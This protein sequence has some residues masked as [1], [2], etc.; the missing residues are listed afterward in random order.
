MLS[1]ATSISKNRER[2]IFLFL[3]MKGQLV[4]VVLKNGLTYEA[5][6]HTVKIKEQQLLIV[7]RSSRQK[8][9]NSFLNYQ[10]LSARDI[11]HISAREIL[12]S[13][14]VQ[15]QQ[16]QQQASSQQSTCSKDFQ[17]DG[18]ITRS[19]MIQDKELVP[20]KPELLKNS[21]GNHGEGEVV[22]DGGNMFSFGNDLIGESLEML[23]AEGFPMSNENSLSSSVSWDQFEV[24]YRNFGVTSTYDEALYTTELDKT[25]DFYLKNVKEAERIAR[26][27]E[28]T[29]T[30][31]VQLK[32]DRGQNVDDYTEEELYSSVK[33]PST[34]TLINTMTT[35]NNNNNN[36]SNASVTGSGTIGGG[37][38]PRGAKRRNN[39]K[40]LNSGVKAV[41]SLNK[42]HDDD[43]GADV[44]TTSKKPLLNTTVIGTSITKQ[45]S[46]VIVSPTASG[47]AKATIMRTLSIREKRSSSLIRTP[48]SPV[49]GTSMGGNVCNNSKQKSSTTINSHQQSLHAA[50]TKRLFGSEIIAERSRSMS[51]VTTP[52][53]IMRSG[54]LE[55]GGVGRNFEKNSEWHYEKMVELSLDPC[56]PK[57]S[58]DVLNKFKEFKETQFKKQTPTLIKTKTQLIQEIKDFSKNFKLLF[59]TLQQD[60][61]PNKNTKN[62]NN[63]NNNFTTIHLM[64][65]KQLEEELQK[66]DNLKKVTGFKFNP[67]AISFIPP[68]MVVTNNNNNNNNNPKKLEFQADQVGGQRRKDENGTFMAKL[69]TT[70]EDGDP[71]EEQEEELLNEELL[72]EEGNFHALQDEGDDDDDDDDNNL[73]VEE[74]RPRISD[75]Y[76]ENFKRRLASFDIN[77]TNTMS[78]ILDG[79][80]WRLPF[81]EN[82][83]SSFRIPEDFQKRQQQQQKQQYY[84]QSYRHYYHPSY[85]QS[86]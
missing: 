3:N 48:P 28:R 62:N 50:M 33:R 18:S 14:E 49:V 29:A 38:R 59:S 2:M 46:A 26:E 5:I 27:I 47:S 16:Q 84:S 42:S 34:T 1:N 22:G 83:R 15:Q 39:N 24:N 57:F 60:S 82:R 73:A 78:T 32:M 52:A 6:F 81:E 71:C 86:H 19:K 79:G 40:G 12:F 68:P 63:N 75:I 30:N 21:S 9:D 85:H 55:A 8:K 56:R 36:S 65:H 31:N 66:Q 7:L 80:T 20:W 70:T 37:E 10:I 72:N 58:E 17:I 53:A 77:T 74:D 54:I 61:N 44:F 51:S 11:V 64:E 23:S 4:N 13:N 67:N 25:S 41:E 69:G 35:T 43:A 45:P 76:L